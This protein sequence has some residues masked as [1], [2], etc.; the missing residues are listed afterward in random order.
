[1]R[2]RLTSL[3]IVAI[4]GAV[5]IVT[6]SSVWRELIQ[7][8]N[9]QFAELRATAAVFSTAIGA[10]V[11]SGDRSETLTSL[12]GITRIPAAKYIEV[13][14]DDGETFAELGAPI[15]VEENNPR[16]AILA[17]VGAVFGTRYEIVR[18]PIIDSGAQ[19]GV[20]AIHA[21]TGALHR[22]IGTIV[23]DAL[24]A[25]LFAAG[26]GLLIALKMQRAITDPILKLADVMRSV[27]ETDNFALR[28]AK[29][30]T[31]DET[32]QLVFA[33]NEMLDQLQERDERLLAHQDDLKKTVHSRTRELRHAKE[34]AEAAN[35]AKSDFLATMSHE[36]R[37]PMNGMMVMAELLSKANLPPRQKRYADVI[38]KSGRSLL[39]IINDILDFSK[40][41]A[42]RLDLEKIPVRPAEI[43]D[44]IVSLFW[45][46]AASRGLDLAAYVAPDVPDEIEGD[47]VRISQVVSNLV[48][49]ALKFTEAGHVVVRVS[50]ARNKN[51]SCAIE[52]SVE[53]T[54]VGISEEKQKTIF[55][56]FSQAD[57][58]TTRRFGGT[59]LGLA[60]CSRLVE[61]MGGEIKVSSRLAKGSRFRFSFPTRSVA[62]P[63][64]APD[65]MSEKRAV[66]AIDGTATPRMLAKYLSESRISPQIVPKGAKIGPEIA[67]ADVIFATPEFLDAWRGAVDSAPDQWSPARIC[68]SELGDAAPDRLLETGVAEDLLI[69][70]LSRD[71]VLDQITRIFDEKLRGQAALTSADRNAARSVSFSGQRILAA[72]DSVVNREVVREALERLGLSPVLV[73]DGREAVRAVY[74]EPFDLILMDCS[75]PEMDG[76]E[77]TRAIRHIEKKLKRTQ[78]PI[79]ALTAH[80]AG[81]DASWRDAGMNDYLT[82]PFTMDAMSDALTRNLK[83]GNRRLTRHSRRAETRADAARPENADDNGETQA[84]DDLFDLDI[85]TQLESMQSGASNL[86]VK[87]LALFR[88]HAA[89]MLKRLKAAAQN[90]DG[91]KI[92][93]AAHALKSTSVNVGAVK[94]AKIC[95]EIE[96][97]AT[98]GEELRSL[99][100]RVDSA[101]TIFGETQQSLPQIIAHFERRAA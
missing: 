62:P 13:V 1:M 87:A 27:R 51:R 35:S 71:D 82:K 54:G 99:R 69:A 68:V 33:F 72:D 77:A 31:D 36:I 48:N 30:E 25:A 23:Y 57:Q 96:I 42:G 79:V 63:R 53:D 89:E 84:P 37:T 94:L 90:D 95:S 73:A 24:V 18:A 16:F 46:R 19:V 86:P 93:K 66:I 55:E 17:D 7:Y 100:K 32:G 5:T 64:K 50:M 65:A 101:A 78:T 43:I 41:E 60:I 61:A 91:A 92:A 75:M 6:V 81:D 14:T 12:R 40:I 8:R 88:E 21:D 28:A 2:G 45:E 3:V 15:I 85:L 97:A 38:A 59:G 4:F 22:R 39:A 70:P 98:Q 80:V 26:I 11:A 10:H 52:F 49:N 44:D 34:V 20:L 47:P 9:M 67:Y 58:S 83:S 76:F 56:A 29:P 74:K